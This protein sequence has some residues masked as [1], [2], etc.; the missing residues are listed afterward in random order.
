VTI[1]YPFR[2]GGS[3]GSAGFQRSGRSSAIRLFGCVLTRP[4]R[5]R[6]YANG[7]T[8]NA[9]HEEVKLIKVAAVWPPRSLPQNNQFGS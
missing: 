6:K 9:L 1:I 8:P 7:S 5:S 2:P 4:S 3:V